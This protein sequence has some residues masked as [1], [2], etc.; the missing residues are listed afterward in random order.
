MTPVRDRNDTLIGAQVKMR[1][2]TAPYPGED[3]IA[4]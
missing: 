4:R 2:V 1:D 3:Q